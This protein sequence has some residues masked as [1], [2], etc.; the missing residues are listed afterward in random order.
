MDSSLC[1][2]MSLSSPRYALQELQAHCLA[3]RADYSD[4]AEEDGSPD[5]M[6][7]DLLHLVVR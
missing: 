3:A 6:V 1:L 2:L 5:F 4:P 7:G